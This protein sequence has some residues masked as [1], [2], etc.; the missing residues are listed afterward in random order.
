MTFTELPDFEKDLIRSLNKSEYDSITDRLKW[1]SKE[2]AFELK[3]ERQQLWEKLLSLNSKPGYNDTK[4][5]CSD[6]SAGCRYCAEGTWSCIFINNRCNASCFYCPAPQKET[7]IPSTNNLTY[8]NVGDY[9]DYLDTFGFKGCSI[10]GGEPLL[11]FDKTLQWIKAIKKRFG[12]NIYLWMYTNGILI[13]K[14]NLSQM[15]GAGLDEI[16]FDIASKNYMIDKVDMAV[17]NIPVVTVEIPAIPGDEAKLKKLVDSL[18]AAGAKHLNLHQLRCTPYNIQSL[19]NRGFSFIHGP[20]I[21]VAHSELTALRTL[22]YAKKTA[23]GLGVNYCSFV[24]KNAFQGRAVRMRAA[25]KLVKS[26]EDLTMAGYI[27]SFFVKGQ[28]DDLRKIENVLLRNGADKSLFSLIPQWNKLCF[29]L[30]VS[31]LIDDDCEVGVDYYSSTLYAEVTYANYFVQIPVGK[32]KKVSAER[33]PVMKG[34]LLP[35]T[36]RFLAKELPGF[37]NEKDFFRYFSRMESIPNIT[38]EEKESLI[39]IKNLE[40]LRYGLQDYF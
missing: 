3:G 35:K 21:L 39:I 20:K 18:R 6:L 9:I 14:K 2:E 4:I 37:E 38:T 28:I 26:Y 27:R 33:Y 31:H 16:R 5:D 23:P 1:L 25:D 11:T 10:S 12:Q 32:S 40:F 17:D 7:G 8:N 15:A 36:G 34:C 13:D 29:S 22:L 30:K 19:A 24:Y